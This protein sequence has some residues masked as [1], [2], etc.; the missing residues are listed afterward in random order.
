M[1]S[2]GGHLC[3]VKGGAMP[4]ATHGPFGGTFGVAVAP[5]R[6]VTGWDITPFDQHLIAVETPG[7][8]GMVIAPGGDRP[9]LRRPHGGH[10]TPARQE[11]VRENLGATAFVKISRY[12]PNHGFTFSF[13]SPYVTCIGAHAAA[14]RNKSSG[15]AGAM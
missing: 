8:L 13:M 10:G 5:Q 4:A 1:A 15:G 12:R 9:P 3:G 14:L 7:C 2:G 11:K 6:M